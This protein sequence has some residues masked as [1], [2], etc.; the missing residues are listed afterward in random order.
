MSKLSASVREA[1]TSAVAEF[2]LLLS[3]LIAEDG[4]L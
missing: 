4:P 2:P 1:V 3:D